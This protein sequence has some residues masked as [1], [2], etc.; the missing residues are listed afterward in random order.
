MVA[1]R[2]IN[3]KFQLFDFQRVKWEIKVISNLGNAQDRMVLGIDL[4]CP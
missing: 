2:T 1:T 4:F 3:H